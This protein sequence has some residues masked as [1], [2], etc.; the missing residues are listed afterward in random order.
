M[1]RRHPAGRL[2]HKLN[3]GENQADGYHRNHTDH[4]IPD[5]LLFSGTFH[6]L[7]F[8]LIFEAVEHF[9]LPPSQETPGRSPPHLPESLH[10]LEAS[11]T[12]GGQGPGLLGVVEVAYG[13]ADE[14][15]GPEG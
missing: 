8:D 4:R 15:G 1:S 9:D 14:Q 10:L 5:P 6:I 7:C 11:V 12:G 3:D 13:S 2:L